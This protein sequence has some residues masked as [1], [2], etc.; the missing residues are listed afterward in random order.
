VRNFIGYLITSNSVI[1][2]KNLQIAFSILQF[3]W[4]DLNTVLEGWRQ[5]KSSLK[6]Q[7][8][9]MRNEVE[10]LS[11]QLRNRQ[12]DVEFC[13]G[14]SSNE[15]EEVFSEVRDVISGIKNYISTKER[16]LAEVH[17]ELDVVSFCQNLSSNID[18]FLISVRCKY[19]ISVRWRHQ[20][21]RTSCRSSS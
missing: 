6:F 4:K 5:T 20:L 12:S 7:I 17:K 19:F 14:L 21:P 16:D 1:S 15:E 10:K 13:K 11:I 18:F 2:T 9:E 8:C 3:C